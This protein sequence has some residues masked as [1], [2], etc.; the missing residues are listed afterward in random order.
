MLNF[1][2]PEFLAFVEHTEKRLWALFK[3]IDRD[4]N[5]VLDREELRI[6]FERA[7]LKIDSS[8]VQR[9]FDEVD[10]NDDGKIT[11]DEWR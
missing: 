8:K 7:G 6:G 3:S 1:L 5:G 9:F 4:G 2:L 11:F 10:V